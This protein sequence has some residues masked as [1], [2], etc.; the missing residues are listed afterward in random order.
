MLI[1]RAGNIINQIEMSIIVVVFK[2]SRNPC[3]KRMAQLNRKC[4]YTVNYFA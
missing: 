1:N 2:N 3:F 4:I